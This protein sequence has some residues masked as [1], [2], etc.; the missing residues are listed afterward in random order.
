M[1]GR[2]PQYPRDPIE[3]QFMMICFV[4][5]SSFFFY[6]IASFS[7]RISLLPLLANL[8]NEHVR[9]LVFHLDHHLCGCF[10]LGARTANAVLC[11][12]AAL[13]SH[14]GLRCHQ[15]LPTPRFTVG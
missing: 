15:D 6:Y 10:S 5:W 11:E 4:T 14:S 3:R 7:I 8:A 2:L 9:H 13:A 12:F 1:Y